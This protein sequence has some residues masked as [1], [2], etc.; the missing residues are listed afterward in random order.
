MENV[1]KIVKNLNARGFRAYAAENGAQAKRIALS[2]IGAGSVGIGGSV[3]VQSLGLYEELQNRG[4]QVFWHWKD[5]AEAR[6]KALLAETYLCSANALTEDG[7]LILTD[8]GGN[9]VASLSFGPENAVVIVGRNKIVGTVEEGIRRIKSAACSGKNAKRL[10]LSTPCAVL[11]E[12]TDCVSPDR[13]CSVTAVFE[14]ASKGLK[15]TFVI[16]VDEELGY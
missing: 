5:G 4:N 10:R 6:K 13:M 8:G 15:N 2:L 9:R 11:G 12:C 14:R 3:T 16:V 1:E 7:C